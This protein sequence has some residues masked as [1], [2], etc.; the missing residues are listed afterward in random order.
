MNDVVLINGSD[1]LGN[2]RRSRA[3]LGSIRSAQN[4]LTGSYMKCSSTG[5]G[6][7]R[8]FLLL[9]LRVRREVFR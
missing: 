7:Q 5:I 6:R 1:V 3:Y 2:I 9:R 4:T 8:G